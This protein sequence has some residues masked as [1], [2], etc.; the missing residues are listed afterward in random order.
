VPYIAL[1][2]TFTSDVFF[3][4]FIADLDRAR[5]WKGL[6]Q[7]SGDPVTFAL[8]AKEAY[9]KLGID[10]TTKALIFSDGLNL[11][12]AQDVHRQIQHLGFLSM[13]LVQS[14]LSHD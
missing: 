3:N 8:R 1:T 5:R 4:E 14:L 9:E 13:L 7:D 2:D 11:E 10:W 12:I 6:R